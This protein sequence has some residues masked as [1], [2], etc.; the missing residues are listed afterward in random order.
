MIADGVKEEQPHLFQSFIVRL[1]SGVITIPLQ[2]LDEMDASLGDLLEIAV[3]PAPPEVLEQ[4]DY[5]KGTPKTRINSKPMV[6]CTRCGRPGTLATSLLKREVVTVKG[7][8]RT[9]YYWQ[10]RVYHPGGV[11]HYI[12]I[13]DARRLGWIPDRTATKEDWDKQK[14]WVRK[15]LTGGDN[16]Q[17]PRGKM[18][19]NQEPCQ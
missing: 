6:D 19:V 4:Y 3:R 13:K 12:S 1:G 18:T 11:Q 10:V 5:S 7:E 15:T 9:Y 17:K 16:M 14:H 8:V 2:V